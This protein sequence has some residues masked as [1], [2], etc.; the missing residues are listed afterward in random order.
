MHM[1]EIMV[2]RKKMFYPISFNT[3]Q[4]HLISIWRE[5]VCFLLKKTNSTDSKPLNC[6]KIYMF[7]G[8]MSQYLSHKFI[9]NGFFNLKA[10]K[11]NIIKIS[12]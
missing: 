8:I 7:H 9:L 2:E 1:R 11:N 6:L 12:P 3:A 10:H 4:I 5:H